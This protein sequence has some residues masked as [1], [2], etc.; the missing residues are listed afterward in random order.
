MLNM[1]RCWW[2]LLTAVKNKLM[3]TL[4]AD[5]SFSLQTQT[6]H[7]VSAPSSPVLQVC[8]A[9]WK[10]E[11]NWSESDLKQQEPIFPR[12][13]APLT[14]RTFAQV[15]SINWRRQFWL[16]SRNFNKSHGNRVVSVRYTAVL[17]WV[18]P[19]ESSS[20]QLPKKH[21]C[22]AEIGNTE[23]ILY[24]SSWSVRYIFQPGHQDDSLSSY[25]YIAAK[26]VIS[27]SHYILINWLSGHC[28][29]L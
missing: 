29:I 8:L 14:F 16:F 23:N 10:E 5:K 17:F 7:T 11:G 3:H 28:N 26:L 19:E 4:L 15:A 12:I 6:Q 21:S 22:H 25:I 9:L 27:L 13:Q 20:Q 2:P 24:C 1:L 18:I